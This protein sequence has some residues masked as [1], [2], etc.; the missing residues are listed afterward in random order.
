[1]GFFHVF[2][3]SGLHSTFTRA[4]THMH[5]AH[6]QHGLA[7]EP[8]LCVHFVGVRNKVATEVQRKHPALVW[9]VFSVASPVP[10]STCSL[11]GSAFTKESITMI[12]FG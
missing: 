2:L 3:F 9:P 4:C 10:N 8:S 5:I 7:T 6:P 11:L 1:M 12:H